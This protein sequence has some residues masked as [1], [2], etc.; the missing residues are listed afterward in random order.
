MFHI[1]PRFLAIFVILFFIMGAFNIYMG[2]R[3]VKILRQHGYATAWY[4][5]VG[6]LTGIEYTLLGVVLL[7]NGGITSGILPSSLTPIIVP[8]Y[9]GVLVLAA[10]VLVVIFVQRM[11]ARRRLAARNTTPPPTT[12]HDLEKPEQSSEQRAL[13]AQRKRERRQKAAAARRRQTGRA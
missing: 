12:P 1:D 6:Y 2:S 4:K 3:R 8:A 7:L 10:I 13:Q 11:N 5:Q 9:I